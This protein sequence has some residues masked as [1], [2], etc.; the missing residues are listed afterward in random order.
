MLDLVHL[1]LGNAFGPAPERIGDAFGTLVD[2]QEQGVIRHLGVSNATADQVAE[3]Q[4]IAPIVSVQNGYNLAYRTDDE[5]IDQLAEQGVAY[6]PFFPLG[7]ADGAVSETLT[8][9]AEKIGAAPRAVALAWL[10]RRS[11][12]V[13][14]IAGTSSVG[15]LH[16]NVT[17][18]TL[19]LESGHLAD[20]DLASSTAG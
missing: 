8:R 9:T 5:L 19:A 16:E 11:P 7:G 15:H 1:R 14:V 12:N 13:L 6:I 20:L 2:L 4:S 18:A 17:G 10:L 3:A